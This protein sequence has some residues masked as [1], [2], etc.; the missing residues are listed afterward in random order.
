MK[1]ENDPLCRPFGLL[2]DLRDSVKECEE[3]D[4][5]PCERPPQNGPYKNGRKRPRTLKPG[6]GCEVFRFQFGNVKP[7]KAAVARVRPKGQRL[8]ELMRE[9]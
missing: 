1:R 5:V 3:L 4:F 9:G 2:H 8:W 7:K 6:V